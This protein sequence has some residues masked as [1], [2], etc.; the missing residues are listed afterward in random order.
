VSELAP[1]RL[2]LPR[3]LVH[4]LDQEV[5]ASGTSR[6]AIVA[7]ALREYLRRRRLTR[8]IA[9][10]AGSVSAEDAPWWSSP[11]AAG[12]WLRELR[13]CWRPGVTSQEVE[14]CGPC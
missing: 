2:K 12:A 5:R 9:E 1:L 13:R 4:Q 11:K 3:D 10:G 7:V 14:T 6:S 8:D